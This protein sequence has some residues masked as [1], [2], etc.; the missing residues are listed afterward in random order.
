MPDFA[1]SLRPAQPTSAEGLMFARY[2]DTAADGV[3]R[4]MLGRGSERV[5]AKAY[6]T[7]GH[8][9][10]FDHVTFA[11]IGG[12]IVGMA[13]SFSSQQHDQSSE[14]PLFRAAGWRNVRM[15]AVSTALFRLFGFIDAVA[16]GDF[17]LHALAVSPERRG[18]GLGSTLFHH[19]EERARNAGAKRLS[20]VVAVD[21]ENAQRLYERMGMTVV[22]TSPRS[23]VMPDGQVHRMAK[24]L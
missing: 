22:A 1:A 14:S 3:F 8:D 24:D 13:S 7:P 12:E 2:L 11:E 4:F 6:L 5:L 20:L 15:A 18:Y 21:N 16:D 19:A 23:L 9:L 17:Y 10:S